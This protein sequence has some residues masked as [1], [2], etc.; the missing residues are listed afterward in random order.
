MRLKAFRVRLFRNVIDSGPIEV[1]DVT[2]LV[3]KNESG[4]SAILQGLH[5]LN[6]M[7]PPQPLNL[8]DEYPRRLKKQHE[9]DGTIDSAVPITA[10]LEMSAEQQQALDERFG[11]GV[12][13]GSEVVAERSYSR[14]LAV[15]VDI[16]TVRFI[17][18]FVGS[19]SERLKAAVGEQTTTA[20]LRGRLAEL[21]A[22]RRDEDA[23]SQSLA[24]DAEGAINALD[25]QLGHGA[26]VTEAVNAL[27]ESWLPRTFYFSQYSQLRGR[28]TVDEVFNAVRNGSAD[29]EVR[30]R[31]TSF[32]WLAGT[33][34]DCGVGL[35][36][37]ERGVGSNIEPS[38]DSRQESLETER[39]PETQS[40]H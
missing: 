12:V 2:C 1:D 6:P 36:G 10:L 35:R 18:G 3:G 30:L 22:A 29:Q 15:R 19:Q 16:R 23:D 25:E 17:S 27:I 34:H 13:I 39:A 33:R 24:S 32:D 5:S 11:S 8:L 37:I 14:G 9:I 7:K 20:P 31:Q 4:K 38:D 26:T 21:V 40:E 28:Y